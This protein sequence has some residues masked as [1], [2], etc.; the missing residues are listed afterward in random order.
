MDQITVH[1]LLGPLSIR[2]SCISGI[3]GACRKQLGMGV[4]WSVCVGN[5]GAGKFPTGWLEKPN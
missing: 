1:V 5:L 4:G 2:A 3:H